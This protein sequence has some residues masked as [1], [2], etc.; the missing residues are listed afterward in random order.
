MILS[1]KLLT[2]LEQKLYT[3]KQNK[4]IKKVGILGDPFFGVKGVTESWF[5]IWWKNLTLIL[6]I[7]SYKFL[8]LLVQKLQA[9]KVRPFFPKF[10]NPKFWPPTKIFWGTLGPPNFDTKNFHGMSL[11]KKNLGSLSQTVSKWEPLELHIFQGILLL[12]RTA[13]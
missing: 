8:T 3:S 1:Y 6:S 9:F 10:Q 4:K 13:P 11:C 5:L 12:Y 7:L 2:L